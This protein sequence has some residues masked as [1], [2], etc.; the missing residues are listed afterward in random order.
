M[1]VALVAPTGNIGS[2]I[3]KELLAKGHEVVGIVRAERPLPADLA[4]MTL[5]VVDIADTA[6]FVA[7]LAGVDALASAYGPAHDNIDTVGDV[8]Q[9]LVAGAKAAGIKRLIVVGGAGS[10]EVAPGMQLVDLPDFPDA[11]KPYAL[12]HRKAYNYLQTVSD[13]DWTFFSPAAEIGPGEKLGGFAVQE[14]R[15]LA[16]A[17]GES[18]IHYPDYATAFVAELEAKQYLNTIITVAYQ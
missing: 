3:A 4:G 17:K 1:K 2:H 18:R 6:A 11:Y 14:K 7:A 10:L 15:F 13:L 9:Q 5:K 12:T 16:N 8:A